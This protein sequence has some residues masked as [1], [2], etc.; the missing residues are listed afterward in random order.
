MTV[1]RFRAF[2]A[3]S[4]RRMDAGGRLGQARAP[5][6]RPRARRQRGHRVRAGLERR[7]H[8]RAC[9]P[10]YPTGRPASRASRHFRRGP[11]IRGR[12]TADPSTASIGRRRTR[13]A[14]GTAA[15]CPA[16]P[17]GNTRR[18]AAPS[19]VP[20][21]WGAANPTSGLYAIS[22][23]N[24]PPGS[25]A[26]SGVTNIAPVGSAPAGA[27][28]WGQ[29]DLAGNLAEWTLDWYVPYATPCVDCVALTDFSYKVLRGG[30]FGTNTDDIFVRPRRRRPRHAQRLR[31]RPLRPLALTSV[32]MNPATETGSGRCVVVVAVADLVRHRCRP[33]R[34]ASRY[35]A[36]RTCE[37]RPRRSR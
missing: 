5:E 30:S 1:G 7:R 31:R 12:E 19:S 14:S 9:R 23:C 37:W 35:R 6:R 29:L 25:T 2:V 13:F 27:G 32:Y 17:S 4:R 10:P 22:G 3:A 16:R 15:F 34:P 33:N 8:P 20:I 11:T 26:C 18:R 24:Y 21:P 36:P 28:L